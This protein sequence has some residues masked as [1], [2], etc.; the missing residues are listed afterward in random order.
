MIESVAESGWLARI[1]TKRRICEKEEI[2]SSSGGVTA[3][4]W[5]HRS[6]NGAI[7]RIIKIGLGFN[8]GVSA[9]YRNRLR[10]GLALEESNINGS[11]GGGVA[12][13]NGLSGYFNGET[14]AAGW[15]KYRLYRGEKHRRK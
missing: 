13:E 5:R 1:S 9:A 12:G 14:S 11:V 2:S 7:N 15:R 3:A 6:I 4:K 10:R 8:G